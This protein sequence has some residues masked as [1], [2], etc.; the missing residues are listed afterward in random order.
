MKF[1]VVTAVVVG[2]NRIID[3][4]LLLLFLFLLSKTHLYARSAENPSIGLPKFDSIFRGGGIAVGRYS[5]FS[6]KRDIPWSVHPLH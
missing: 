2:V 6:I 5:L 1:A 3:S 4:A